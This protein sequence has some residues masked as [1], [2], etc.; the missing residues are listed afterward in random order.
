MGLRQ[1]KKGKNYWAIHAKDFFV[2]LYWGGI[3]SSKNSKSLSFSTPQLSL[4][5]EQ[6]LILKK[7]KEGYTQF[8]G[9]Q[10]KPKASLTS[11]A[12]SE[13]VTN[14]KLQQEIKKTGYAALDVLIQKL[15]NSTRPADLKISIQPGLTPKGIKAFQK[16]VQAKCKQPR[17]HFP[18]EYAEFL[19][20]CG[21]VRIESGNRLLWIF[22]PIE[23][24]EQ[25]R[26]YVAV[27]RCV[28]W[29]SEVGPKRSITTAHLFGFATTEDGE[30]RWCIDT[31]EKTKSARIFLHHQDEPLAAH[32]TKT[33]KP[34][35]ARL[36]P[37]SPTFGA[38][39]K[40]HLR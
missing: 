23:A 11:K 18:S 21:G 4:I 40:K 36:K 27:P 25:T 9:A 15:V 31:S 37:D 35:S 5:H 29:A 14:N 8:K 20:A 33:G 7:L 10:F 22:S 30:A 19:L 24:F 13:K 26:K 3:S 34:I 28:K 32:D 1:F 38:W 39:L 17:F 6:K 2:T 16:K 12:T